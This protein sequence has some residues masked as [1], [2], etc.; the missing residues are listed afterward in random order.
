MYFLKIIKISTKIFIDSS[1]HQRSFECWRSPTE[2][3]QSSIRENNHG[4]SA[5]LK[6]KT[7]LNATGKSISTGSLAYIKTEGTKFK[8]RERY[9][10]MEI[11]NDMATLQKL[12]ESVFSSKRYDIPLQNLFPVIPDISDNIASNPPNPSTSNQSSDTSEDSDDEHPV[13]QNLPTN[14]VEERQ[15]SNRTRWARREPAW[16]R[17]EEWEIEWETVALLWNTRFCCAS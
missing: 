2:C 6:A 14:A 16:L 8:G 1:N 10:V 3:K 13:H 5:K 15:H 7:L 4:P 17:S 12:N 11:R 9:I